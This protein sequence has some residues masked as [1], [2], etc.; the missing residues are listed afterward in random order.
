[1]QGIV[2]SHVEYIIHHINYGGRKRRELTAD[3]S[4]VSFQYY[5]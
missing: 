2:L 3:G 1:M 4:F 5:Y